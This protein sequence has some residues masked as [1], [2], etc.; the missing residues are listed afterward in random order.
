MRGESKL[1][2]T[3]GYNVHEEVG[4]KGQGDVGSES[5]G[6]RRKEGGSKPKAFTEWKEFIFP[7]FSLFFKKKKKLE[8]MGV[9]KLGLIWLLL[10][11]H[12]SLMSV[13]TNSRSGSHQCEFA[14]T[15][16]SQNN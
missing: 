10:I 7:F 15:T 6:G 1:K 2:Q 11:E 16:R 5:E 8:K 12:S 9:E 3:I 4:W 14:D 13:Y